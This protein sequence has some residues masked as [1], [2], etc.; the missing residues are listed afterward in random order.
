M[1][2]RRPPAHD[3]STEQAPDREPSAKDFALRRLRDSPDEELAVFVDS[4][5]QDALAAGA[6]EKELRDAQ[7]GHPEHG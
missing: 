7:S 3:V 5:R 1:G 2:K 6:T 4:L